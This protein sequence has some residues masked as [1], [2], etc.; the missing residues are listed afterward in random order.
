MTEANK[1]SP[2]RGFAGRKAKTGSDSHI[3]YWTEEV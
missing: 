1:Q 2:A 3:G